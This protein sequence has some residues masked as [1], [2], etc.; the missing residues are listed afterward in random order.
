[1]SDPTTDPPAGLRILT[2]ERLEQRLRQDP[3]DGGLVITPVLDP[4]RQVTAT[5][6]DLRLG[7]E[8]WVSLRTRNAAIDLRNA[9]VDNEGTAPPSMGSYFERTFRD[10]G[11]QFVLYPTHFVLG[12]TF[13]YVRMPVDLC[14]EMHAR[15]SLSRA[16]VGIRGFVQ[17]GYMGV[18]TLE[19]ANDSGNTLVLYPGMRAVQ[20]TFFEIDAP[21]GEDYVRTEAAKYLG[22]IGPQIS[23]IRREADWDVLGRMRPPRIGNAPLALRK[24]PS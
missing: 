2:G 9:P 24:P 8:F 23:R 6:V 18:L 21:A 20:L 14:A 17:P 7:T 19:L 13:E 12:C 1:M 10:F 11:E 3:K 4:E 5:T 15:S 22:G 16:G